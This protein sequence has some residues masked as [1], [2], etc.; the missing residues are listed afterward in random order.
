MIFAAVWHAVCDRRGARAAAQVWRGT[1]S[2]GKAPLRDLHPWLCIVRPCRVVCLHHDAGNCPDG[3]GKKTLIAIV[4][5]NPS[6]A[7]KYDPQ[8]GFST[9]FDLLHLPL[10]KNMTRRVKLCITPGD[11]PRRGVVPGDDGRNNKLHLEGATQG[12]K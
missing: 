4:R 12:E 11:I 3:S 7:E 8:R 2:T 5:I 6:L 10:G 1:C 9:V